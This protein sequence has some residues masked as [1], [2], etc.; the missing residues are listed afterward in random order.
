MPRPWIMSV[1]GS[2]GGCGKT[3]F[4]VRLLP[5]LRDC[6][7]IKAE[8]EENLPFSVQCEDTAPPEPVKDTERFLAAGAL[9][10]CLIRGPFDRTLQAVRT[11]IESRR[12][13]GVV[14]ESNSL[15][16]RIRQ[17]LAVFVKGDGPAKP[18]AA[19]LEAAAD[20]VTRVVFDSERDDG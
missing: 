4:I 2:H 16:R 10:A 6:A 3:S 15:F 18:G 19:E 20:I 17:D 12:F 7:V 5:C 13:A 8:T 14:V 9:R 1:A 11:I